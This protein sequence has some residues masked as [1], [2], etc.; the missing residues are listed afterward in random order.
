MARSVD[1]SRPIMAPSVSLT[2]PATRNMARDAFDDQWIVLIPVDV[3]LSEDQANGKLSR[4]RR[5][6]HPRDSLPSAACHP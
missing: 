3:A 6:A 2:V 4:S 5:S 1:S